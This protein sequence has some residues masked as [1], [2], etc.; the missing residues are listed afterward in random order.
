[1]SFSRIQYIKIAKEEGHTDEFIH[2]TLD[3]AEKLELQNLPVIFSTLH[4]SMLIGVEFHV[5]NNI[6]KERD[7]FYKNYEIKKKK[8]GTQVIASGSGSDC[9]LSGHLRRPRRDFGGR[10]K[11]P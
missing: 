3:Y 7:N 4:L 9:H 1:M 5:M 6:I 8:G 10:S 11:L 2:E